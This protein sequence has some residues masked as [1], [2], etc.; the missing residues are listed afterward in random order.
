MKFPNFPTWKNLLGHGFF[1]WF[2]PICWWAKQF[3]SFVFS[4]LY[5]LEYKRSNLAIANWK[6]KKEG[7][8]AWMLWMRNHLPTLEICKT[9]NMPLAFK[10]WEMTQADVLK[11]PTQESHFHWHSLTHTHTQTQTGSWLLMHAL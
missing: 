6:R 8:V 4:V 2:A 3:E 5:V 10:K 11:T 9:K 1:N 7:D